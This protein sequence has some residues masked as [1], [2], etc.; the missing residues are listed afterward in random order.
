MDRRLKLSKKYFVPTASPM[1]KHLH[2]CSNCVAMWEHIS[3]RCAK[4]GHR[5]KMCPKCRVR[6]GESSD[7]TV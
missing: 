2:R 3:T 6:I 1:Q 4:K 5:S 7:S